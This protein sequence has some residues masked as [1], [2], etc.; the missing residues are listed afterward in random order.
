MAG[1]EGEIRVSNCDEAAPL[2]AVL[3]YRFHQECAKDPSLEA[4]NSERAFL[5]I[6]SGFPL[7]ELEESLRAGKTIQISLSGHEGSGIV[8]PER[9]GGKR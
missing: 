7:S 2:L 9:L 4:A 5:T 8:H 3:G 6:D 1:P